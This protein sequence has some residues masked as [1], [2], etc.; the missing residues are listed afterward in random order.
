MIACLIFFFFNDT[1]TTDIYTLSLHDALPIS[2]GHRN[3]PPRTASAHGPGARTVPPKGRRIPAGHPPGDALLGA[4]GRKTPAAHP[5][6][7]DGAA[8]WRRREEP[9][10]ACLLARADPHVFAGP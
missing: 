6:S 5:V 10:Q 9:A 7:R 1:A 2:G 4:G 3:F 8:F